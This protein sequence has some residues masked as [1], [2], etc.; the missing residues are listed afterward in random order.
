MSWASASWVCSALLAALL[1]SG[2][3]DKRALSASGFQP[4]AGLEDVPDRRTGGSV[5]PVP[6]WRAQGGEVAFSVVLRNRI[7]ANL[8]VTGVVRDEDGDDQQFVPTGIDA[9]VR[10]GPG[11]RRRIEVR[12]RAE[13]NG[14]AGGQVSGKN[15]QW[16]T[17][18]DG[19]DL[20]VDLGVLLEFVCR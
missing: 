19:S 13:C 8:H 17:L 14:R 3:G 9:P 4:L 15:D 7:D 16:F 6:T 1:V 18:D 2:C 12:G 20:D 5:E 10:L 11:D